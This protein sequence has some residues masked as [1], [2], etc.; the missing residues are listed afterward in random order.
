MT[1]K[2]ELKKLERFYQLTADLSP[3]GWNILSAELDTYT[4]SFMRKYKDKLSW[5]FLSIG[6]RLS[7]EF[8]REMKDYVVWRNICTWSKLTDSFIRE[9]K[10]KV[11]WVGVSRYQDLS[12]N[13]I[14]EFHNRIHFDML[15]INEHIKED[16][17][18]QCERIYFVR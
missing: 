15:Y 10:D 18:N 2:E 4:E 3:N 12:W 13:L 8:I 6:G 7:E 17:W 9:M 5:E 1:E 14:E 11:D 16:V